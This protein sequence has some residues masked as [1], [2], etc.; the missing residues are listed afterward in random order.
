MYAKFGRGGWSQKFLSGLKNSES[1][2]SIFC[3]IKIFG[4]KSETFWIV[5]VEKLKKKWGADP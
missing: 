5:P 2:T 3:S 4:K 1:P